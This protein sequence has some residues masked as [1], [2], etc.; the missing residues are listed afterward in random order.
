MT[1][2]FDPN[3]TSITIT[4]EAYVFN[5]PQEDMEEFTLKAIEVPLGGK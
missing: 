1:Q 3:A 5:N 4:P 2:A